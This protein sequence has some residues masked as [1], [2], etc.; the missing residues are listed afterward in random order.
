VRE[1][2]TDAL[3]TLALVLIAAGAGF[4]AGNWIGWAGLGVSGAVIGAGSWLAQWLPARKA[5]GGN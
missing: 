2:L 3:D 4:A 5:R 1:H